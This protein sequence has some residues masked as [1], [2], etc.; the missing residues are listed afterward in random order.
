MVLGKLSSDFTHIAE[1]NHGKAITEFNF[2]NELDSMIF[3]NFVVFL[4]LRHFEAKK[5]ERETTKIDA[6]KAKLKLN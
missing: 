3:R 2:D 4:S 6:I 1:Q 5:K